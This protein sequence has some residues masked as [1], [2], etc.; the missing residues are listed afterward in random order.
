MRDPGGRL[1]QFVLGRLPTMTPAAARRAARSLRVQVEGG[2]DPIAER[3]EK[4]VAGAELRAGIG[5][6]GAL[7]TEQPPPLL[8][9]IRNVLGAARGITA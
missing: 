4:R 2:Y 3:R 9:F 6:L 1:R 5:T 7:L 8:L